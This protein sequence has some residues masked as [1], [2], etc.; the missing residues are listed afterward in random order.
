VFTAVYRIDE[1]HSNSFTAWK[2][3]GSPALP[4]AAQLAKI[5]NASELQL[6]PELSRPT[7]FTCGGGGGGGG[8][9]SAGGETFAATPPAATTTA[10]INLQLALPST[11]LVMLCGRPT[12]GPS[13]VAKV[14]LHR[15]LTA[16]PSQV[17][18]SWHGVSEP[19]IK[20]Y[21]V[22]HHHQPSNTTTTTRGGGGAGGTPDSGSIR[23]N[24]DDTIFTSF[25]H[26]QQPTSA[27]AGKDCYYV[28]AHD[29]WGREGLPSDTLCV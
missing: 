4:T 18:V 26:A 3:L 11:H 8:G 5:R 1:Q 27:G 23:V 2:A 15:T 24:Q 17:L 6:V 12:T 13:T 10:I 16:A 22:Y 7:E 9:N 21:A 25:L 20:T 14:V 28:T 29:F 19:C